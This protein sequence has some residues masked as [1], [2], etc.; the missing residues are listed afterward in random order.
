MPITSNLFATILKTESHVA[1]YYLVPPI[2]GMGNI[3]KKIKL[4][5]QASIFIM[6]MAM[7]EEMFYA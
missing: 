7:P 3:G 1:H 2:Y 5:K 6:V 4:P